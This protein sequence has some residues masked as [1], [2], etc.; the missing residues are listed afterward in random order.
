MAEHWARPIPAERAPFRQRLRA[1]LE[2]ADPV[3]WI[4]PITMVICGALAA[5]QGDPGFHV[6]DARDIL[7]VV[8]TALMCGPFGTGFS[9]S[10][11]DY[12]DRELDAIND[13]SRPIPSQ[14]ITLRAARGNWIGLGLATAA[15]SLF[16]AMESLWMPVL[17]AMSLILAAA[18]SVPP[19]KLKQHYWLGPPA[20]GFGYVFLSWMAGHMIFAP[21]TW[22]SFTLAIINS[23]LA[24]GLLFLND[25]KSIE[26]DRKHGLQSMTV[27]FGARRTLLVSYAII[28]ICELMLLALALMSG[29]LWAAAIAALALIVPLNSQ[30]RLYREPTHKNFLR[31]IVASNPFI[32]LIQFVSALIVGG[33][34]G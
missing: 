9:Q 22:P 34:F 15:V 1:H 26:G 8:L 10:I 6:N 28:G 25:I 33:Y 31:Y 17:A 16:L 5:G 19:V 18:Y 11:N 3:T 21:L 20:V 27:A 2:L 12:F 7:L 30:V 14:R 24:A 23:A 13:P 29:H 32:L 4:T